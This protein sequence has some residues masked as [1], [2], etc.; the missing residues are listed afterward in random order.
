[1]SDGSRSDVNW[2][3]WKLTPR[4]LARAC[5]SVVLP[6]PGTSSIRR[7]PRASSPITASRTTSGLPTRARATLNSSR[8]IS[9]RDAMNMLRYL[10]ECSPFG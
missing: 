1:M 7:C 9:S 2:M 10:L 3:R 5:A 6:T 8:R 4:D